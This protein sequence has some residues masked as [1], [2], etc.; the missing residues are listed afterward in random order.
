MIKCC[1][2]RKKNIRNSCNFWGNRLI[3]EHY[4][5]NGTQK[6]PF[7]QPHYRYMKTWIKLETTYKPPPRVPSFCQGVICHIWHSQFGVHREQTQGVKL[8]NSKIANY[9]SSWILLWWPYL[10]KNAVWRAAGPDL[11]TCCLSSSILRNATIQL[12]QMCGLQSA[13]GKKNAL[14]YHSIHKIKCMLI[15]MLKVLVP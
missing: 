1:R 15:V 6:A 7:L 11:E 3:G 13:W 9:N 12:L 5:L 10:L 4:C 14:I 8:G 2:K